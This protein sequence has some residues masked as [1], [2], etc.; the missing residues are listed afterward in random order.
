MKKSFR[1]LTLITAVILMFSLFSCGKSRR[2]DIA[3]Y[4]DCEPKTLLV[5]YYERTVGTPMKMPYYE[6]VL[7][8]YSDTHALLEEYTEGGTEDETVT[9]YLVPLAEAQN[10]LTSVKATGM[11]SWNRKSGTAICGRAYVCK[12]PDGE[13][14]Y[15]RVT[16]D[17]MPENGS[18]LF[19]EVKVAMRSCCKDEYAVGN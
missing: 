1:S 4:K 5:D 7:Y 6:L 19:G 13:G 10:I 16:S 12:F 2:F 8:T 3:A 14:G 9:S 17:N 15:T 11:A 18:A